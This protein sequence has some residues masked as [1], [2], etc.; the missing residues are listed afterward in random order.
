MKHQLVFLLFLGLDVLILLYE[1]SGIS[2][3]FREARTLYDSHTLLSF[4]VDGSLSLFGQNDFALRLPMI[5]MHLLSVVLF[6]AITG[7]YLIRGADR[8]WLTLI[9][10]LLPGVNSAA[11]LVDNSGLII[12]AL[13]FYVY[14]LPYSKKFANILLLLYLFIDVAFA[15]AYLALFFYAI[16]RKQTALLVWSLLL[17]GTSMYLHGF[18]TYGSPKGHFLDVMGLYA[19]VFSPIVFIYLVYILFRRYVAR[20]FDLLWYLAVVPFLLSLLLSF[21]QELEIQMFAPY[22]I[23][24]MPLAAQNFFHSYRVRLK[25]F[26]RKY[27]VLFA[28][29]FALLLIN[30]LAVFLNKELYRFMEPGQKHFAHKQHVAKELAEILKSKGLECVNANDYKMQ[31]R[32][33]FYGIE[34]CQSPR[35]VPYEYPDSSVV[36][37][38]YSGV[39][40]YTIYVTKIP[41]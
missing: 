37:I 29:S 12:L 27:R 4:I 13:L 26:R 11:L 22:L 31:M 7:R 35:F 19:A 18:E 21:R 24:A 28:L 25:R 1:S 8:L 39:P 20:E 16:G 3:S 38:S 36:T 15:F 14:I 9:F 5:G 40:A 23:L 33:R 32:L 2:I 17:F 6:Y 34:K 41:K 10:I 30:A